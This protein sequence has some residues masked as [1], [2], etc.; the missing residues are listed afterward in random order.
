MLWQE[1]NGGAGGSGRGS[2]KDMEME[3][4]FVPGL[5]GLGAR[6]MAGKRDAA[7]RKSES[8]WDALQ[9]RRRSCIARPTSSL[10][11]LACRAS[12]LAAALEM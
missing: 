1:G 11:P 2:G 6:L 7:A 8:I 9:R 3:V 12:G 10:V 5:E 4:T